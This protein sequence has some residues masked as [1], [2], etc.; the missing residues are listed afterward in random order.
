MPESIQA[1]Q[2]ILPN[3]HSQI[4]QQC[5]HFPWEEQPQAF[6]NALDLAL[7]R[8]A[9]VDDYSDLTPQERAWLLDDSELN[10]LVNA[11]D[12]L[13][14]ETRFIE[15]FD[16]SDHYY[17]TNQIDLNSESLQTGWATLTQCH[18]NLD[19]V[20]RLQIVYHP[21]HTKNLTILE[22]Q[23]IDLSRVEDTSIQMNS[24]Q[25]GAKIC[26]QAD[27]YALK[28]QKNGYRIERGP[29]MRKFLD[30]YYPL[31]VE[32]NINWT[33]LPLALSDTLPNQQTGVEIEHQYQSLKA[34]YW[35]RG[36]LRPQIH[37]IQQP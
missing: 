27:T 17:M 8:E 32:L 6:Y 34:G 4:L 11:L 28:A 23:A 9:E 37:F 7:T 14:I 30:G 1:Y 16:L 10:D 20:A 36:E 29:F 24:L 19:P 26:V 5:A 2:S 18:Y 3:L 21:E 31:Y 35:F 15:P 22:D 12:N 25:K 33:G 13:V